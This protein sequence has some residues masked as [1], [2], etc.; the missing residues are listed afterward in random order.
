MRR[1][2]MRLAGRVAEKEG[3]G[4]LITGGSLGQVASQT[5]PSLAVTESVVDVP[6]LRPLIGLDKQEIVKRAQ[7]LGTYSISIRPYDDCCTVFV[8]RHPET[9]P[10]PEAVAV[11]EA[12]LVAGELIEEALT[13]A[14]I[15]FITSDWE[16]S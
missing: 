7:D 2:M 14:E 10:D 6:V 5:L 15:L 9:R 1:M 4:A 13:E 8:P 11:K 12:G 3:A 16:G